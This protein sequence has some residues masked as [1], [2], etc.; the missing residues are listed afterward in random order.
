MAHTTITQIL[1]SIFSK[2]AVV[3]AWMEYILLIQTTA[4]VTSD[5]QWLYSNKLYN[6]PRFC[7]VPSVRVKER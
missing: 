6:W 5:V 1:P 2:S 7:L 3:V 4:H